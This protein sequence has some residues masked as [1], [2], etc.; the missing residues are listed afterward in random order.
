ML[1][2]ALA[3]CMAMMF[4]VWLLHLPLKNA[5]IVDVAW[6]MGICASALL[7]CTQGSGALERR[8]LIAGMV[9][10]WA[11]RLSIYLLVARVWGKPEE[12]RY[13]ELR[14]EYGDSATW[15][16]LLFFQI[17]ALS[18]VVLAIPVLFSARNGAKDISS[19][20]WLALGVW[21]VAMAGELVADWQLSQF[22]GIKANRGLVCRDGLWA[23]SRHPNYFFEW[24]IWVS[25]ALFALAS[26]W[27]FL[28]ILSPLLIYYFVNHVTGIPPTEAQ[29]LRS[30]G[31]AYAKYQREV[32]AFFPL[33]PR[34]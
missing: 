20:E 31:E 1:G 17:Q 24:L 7:F 4:A 6:P 23:W 9:T 16:F 22:K 5:A 3:L 2:Q 21:I 34:R 32:S 25:Y 14:R 10:F 8:I 18:C 28:G 27:G 19:L 13:Q 29:A 11:L 12:G 15:R 33:P 26:P 30:R